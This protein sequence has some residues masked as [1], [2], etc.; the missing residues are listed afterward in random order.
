MQLLKGTMAVAVGG[1]P[2]S[3]PV[4]RDFLSL[5][6][7]AAGGTGADS[8]SGVDASVVDALAGVV[9]AVFLVLQTQKRTQIQYVLAVLSIEPG[10]LCNMKSYMQLCLT[11]LKSQGA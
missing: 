10:I 8:A 11:V 9:D 5:R 4:S 2:G 1:C 6:C 7:A 3:S